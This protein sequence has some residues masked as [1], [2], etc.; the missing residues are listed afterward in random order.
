MQCLRVQRQLC[1]RSK[2]LTLDFCVSKAYYSFAWQ[3][4]G[5]ALLPTKKKMGRPTDS[6]KRHEV[7]ARV[8]D[9]TLEILDD[10]CNQNKKNRAQ[11]IRDGIHRLK[12]IPKK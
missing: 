5:G 9:E 6:P 4:L 1:E 3:K 10:Y 2:A 7:S 12:E 11:G 8:D